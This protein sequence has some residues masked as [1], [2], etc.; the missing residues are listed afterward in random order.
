VGHY[1]FGEFEV[2]EA[3]FALTRD[4]RPRTIQPKPLQLL[5]HL[6]RRHPDT[7]TKD[8]LLDALWPDE[9]V[10][11]FSLT[12]AV[13]AARRALGAGALLG[14]AFLSKYFA[15]LVALAWVGWALVARARGRWR[16]TALALAGALGVGIFFAVVDLDSDVPTVVRV[17]GQIDGAGTALADF[18]DDDVLADFRGYVG[19]AF[20]FAYLARHI[21]SAC[22][23]MSHP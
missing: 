17:V 13:R 9:A 10:T 5:L 19:R 21:V 23:V 15:V 7:V 16:V 14:L 12:R 6:L 20:Y 8:E 2:D 4:G 22:Q 1:R 18:V 11:E 3:R